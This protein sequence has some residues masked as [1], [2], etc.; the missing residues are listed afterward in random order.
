MPIEQTALIVPP[1]IQAG[2]DSGEL[3]KNGSV[4][5]DAAG[6]I[7]KHLEEVPL[8]LG[9]VQE[10]AVALDGAARK[11]VNA[12]KSNPKATFVIA[13]VGVVVSSATS[14]YLNKAKR[15][16]EAKVQERVSIEDRFSTAATTWIDAASAG[17][18]TPDI[19]SELQDAWEAYDASNKEWKAQP[20]DLAV[21]LMQ[22]V[23]TWNIQNGLSRNLP[24]ATD[25]STDDVVVNLSEYLTAQ[26]EML[27]ETA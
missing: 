8:N 1:I 27:S 19:V 17:A 11:V 9:K 6:H 23:K 14:F 3:F 13:G 2:I 25:S 18:V 7:V 5:R 10:F 20:N 15:S 22:L 26:R 24:A 16:K 12:A 21:S 4:V